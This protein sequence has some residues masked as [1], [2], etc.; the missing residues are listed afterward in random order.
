MANRMLIDLN[1]N[2]EQAVNIFVSLRAAIGLMIPT[3]IR[4][5]PGGV[6]IIGSH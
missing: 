5:K 6:V 2:V 1:Q 3:E 4:Y